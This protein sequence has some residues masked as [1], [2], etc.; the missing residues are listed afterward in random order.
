MNSE[1][2]SAKWLWAGIGLQLGVGYLVYTIGTL[3]TAPA[4]LSVGPALGGLAA[5]L[6]FAGIIIALIGHTNRK[7]K[8]EYALSNASKQYA[9][10][11]V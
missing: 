1:M 9:G 5:V 10:S 6:V 8:A 7:L 2:K 11:N 3:I 4:T